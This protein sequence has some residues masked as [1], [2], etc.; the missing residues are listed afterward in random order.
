MKRNAGRML[1]YNISIFFNE[2]KKLCP[3][4]REGG[5][6]R[7]EKNILPQTH[8]H[9]H[10]HTSTPSPAVNPEIK[11]EVGPLRPSLEAVNDFM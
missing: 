3:L 11:S 2:G 6:G 4:Y 9:M 5:G 10:L 1:L 7:R 8:T